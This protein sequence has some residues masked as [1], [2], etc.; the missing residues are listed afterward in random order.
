LPVSYL[1]ALR[2]LSR[3]VRLVL[4][5]AGLQGFSANGIYGVLLNLF[6]LRLGYGPEFVGLVNG[7]GLLASALFC[8]PASMVGR[9]LGSRRALV[10]GE[11]LTAGG[12]AALPLTRLL[13]AEIVP[14]TLIGAY[15]VANMG[16]ALRAV[17]VIPYLMGAARPEARSHAFS[18]YHA[19]SPGSGMLGSLVG[20][21]LPPFFASW[22]GQDLTAP[23]PYG[24]ALLVGAVFIL[25]AAI[26]VM[27]A[28]DIEEGRPT[29]A[30]TSS[31]PTTP[32]PLGLM[33]IMATVLMIRVAG[34]RSVSIYFNVYMDDVLGLPT[35][36]IG[37]I[38]ATG[39]LLAIPAALTAPLLTGRL[40]NGKTYALAAL[41]M[42]LSLLP[43]ALIPTWQ[44]AAVSYIGLIALISVARPA[45]IVHQQSLVKP[46]WR[47]TMAGI[48]Q[49]GVAIGSSGIAYAGGF[50][51]TRAGYQAVFLMGA[52]LIAAGAGLFWGYF[53]VPR[54]ELARQPEV[55][56]AQPAAASGDGGA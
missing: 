4:L 53:R 24:A 12:Y 39:Q 9:R 51:A 20:G 35:P 14:V 11:L 7:S 1:G 36:L 21:L 44:A 25:P 2:G 6:L 16:G 30:G 3:N 10:I 5:A 23:G 26:A 22:L 52:A 37:T 31:K 33:L 42:A 13:P 27:A 28:H 38:T 43:L 8:V 49:M 19:I 29:S 40:G 46:E 48:Q 17:N 55:L 54:G 15:L 45:V 41:G 56:T 47:S 32:M 34:D 50:L 18:L